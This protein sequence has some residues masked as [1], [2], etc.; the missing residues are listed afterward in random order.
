M[1][2]VDG[3]AHAK[4][5]LEWILK[6]LG[7]KATIREACAALGIGEAAFHKLRTRFLCEAVGLLEPRAVG[8]PPEAPEVAGEDR[9]RALEAEVAELRLEH[10]AAEVRTELA[11]A[12][13][14]L[15]KRREKHLYAFLEVP[16][17]DPCRTIGG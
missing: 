15:G 14:E 16:R 8:R 2:G 11:L 10:R 13:P 7:G 3:S 17:C 1:R 12:L 4:R 5:R 9:V 6:T